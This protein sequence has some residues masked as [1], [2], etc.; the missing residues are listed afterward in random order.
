MD[1]VDLDDQRI[2]H[3]GFT[4]TRFEGTTLPF[5]DESFD[6]VVSNHVIEHVGDRTAQR[7]HLSEIRRVLRRDG[8]GYLAVPNRWALVEP[9]Y[10]L[11]FLSWLPRRIADAYLRLTRNRTPYDC[12]PPGPLR[13]KRLLRTTGLQ[14]TSAAGSAI[15]A[16]GEVEEGGSAARFAALF[17]SRLLDL[18]WA[19]LPTFILLLR[20]A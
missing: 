5:P 1:A 14:S 9:H 19:V 18:I 11:A 6:V 20:R 10:R 3:E 4:F 12:H 8:L 16:M 2:V 15:Q 17:P 13:L 7:D